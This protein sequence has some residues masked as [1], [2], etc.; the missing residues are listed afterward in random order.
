MMDAGLTKAG[1]TKLWSEAICYATQTANVCFNSVKSRPPDELFLGDP[2][3]FLEYLQPLFHFVDNN[4]SVRCS[5]F[6]FFFIS[7]SSSNGHTSTLHN[8]NKN[9]HQHYNSSSIAQRPWDCDSYN[10]SNTFC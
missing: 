5:L 7:L 6:A 3:K 4:S 9:H 8:S 1:R 10:N 2:S